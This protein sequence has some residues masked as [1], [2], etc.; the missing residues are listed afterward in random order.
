MARPLTWGLAA[1]VA[2][3]GRRAVGEV[4]GAP[5]FH[6]QDSAWL[7]RAESSP[8]AGHLSSLTL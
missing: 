7:R 4:E 3:R 1:G 8:G 6:L 5:C 2:Q